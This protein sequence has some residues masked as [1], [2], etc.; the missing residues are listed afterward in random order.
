MRWLA[1]VT[2]VGLAFTLLHR[3]VRGRWPGRRPRWLAD[4]GWL[5]FT[6]LVARPIVKIVAAVPAVAV[7]AIAGWEGFGP[8]GSLPDPVQLVLMLILAD[9]LGYWAHRAFHTVPWMWRFHA[10]HHSSPTLD[11]LAAARVH[12]VNEVLQR[13]PL[14]LAA[15][16]LGFRVEVVAVATPILALHGLLL[17][18]DVPWSFG[19]VGRWVSSPRFHRTHHA[20]GA[21][22]NFA[23]LSPVWDRWFG[24]ASFP[25]DEPRRFGVDE[26]IPGDLVRA[27]LWPFRRAPVATA[28]APAP[29]P[30]DPIRATPPHRGP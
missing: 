6:P 7:A 20:H 3:G 9:F 24:T 21:A 14:A 1:G 18:A 4:L 30:P 12:P 28:P 17:H 5:W 19:P 22:V 23:G 26:P 11:W 10:V 13:V 2:A 27:F 25:Q 15:I 29:G 16:G 8:L